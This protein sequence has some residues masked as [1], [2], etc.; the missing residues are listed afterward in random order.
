VRLTKNV[1]PVTT[2]DGDDREL[3]QDNGTTDGGGDFLGAL[4]TQTNVAVRVTDKD[5]SLES[6]SLTGTGLFLDRHDLHDLVLELGQEKVD[7]LELLDGEGEEVDLLD[8]LNLAVLDQS[9]Q[10][11]DGN[12]ALGFLASSSAAA[13]GTTSSSSSV[14]ATSSSSSSSALG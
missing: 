4:D 14:S 11:G 2:T 3:G 12:P 7:D 9:A 1:T 13:T 5:K 8:G 6:G 10:L